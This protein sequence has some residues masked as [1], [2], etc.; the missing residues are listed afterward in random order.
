MGSQDI[1]LGLSGSPALLFPLYQA[2]SSRYPLPAD[3]TWDASSILFPTL[4]KILA[5]AY[6]AHGLKGQ[7]FLR[8]RGGAQK[9]PPTLCLSAA[10]KEL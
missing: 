5:R 6:S 10:S 2:V 1:D 3:I 4:L 7:P 8:G 9:G